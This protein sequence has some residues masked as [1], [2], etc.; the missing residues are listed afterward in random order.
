MKRIIE[1]ADRVFELTITPG[2]EVPGNVR[3]TATVRQLSGEPLTDEE[4][5]ATL[6]R[7]VAEAVGDGLDIISWGAK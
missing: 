2:D 3:R 6:S 1:T 7:C 4:W 5:L